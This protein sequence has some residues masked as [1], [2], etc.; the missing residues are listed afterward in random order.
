MNVY[1]RKEGIEVCEG[2]VVGW[3][4]IRDYI[5]IRA[6]VLGGV[7]E[8]MIDELLENMNLKRKRTKEEEEEEDREEALFFAHLWKFFWLM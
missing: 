2:V 6:D 8:E 5:G 4:V 1:S 7:E 3:Y